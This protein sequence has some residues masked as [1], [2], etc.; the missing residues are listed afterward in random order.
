M[1]LK[2]IHS[3]FTKGSVAVVNF[4]IL[5][6]SSRYLGVSTRGE[7]SLIIL[8]L[9]VIQLI[10]EVYTGYSLV[11]YISK[12]NIHKIYANGVIFTL[13]TTLATNAVFYLIGEQIE[14]YQLLFL[15]L[16]VMVILN[17]FNCVLILAREFYKMYN[18]LSIIQPALLL[19]GIFIY[20]FI[21]KDFTLGAFLWPLLISFGISLSVSTIFVI[22][23]VLINNTSQDFELKPILINGLYCQLAAL[24]YVLSSRLSYYLLETKPDVGLSS[25]SSSLLGSGL[26]VTNSVT[27][28]LLSKVAITGNNLKSVQLTQ[29]LAKTCMLFSIL[30]IAVVYLIPDSLFILLLGNTFSGSKEIMMLLSPGIIFLSFSGIISHYYSGIGKLKTVSFYNFFGFAASIVLAPW[31]IKDHGI[32]GAALTTNVAYFI[33]FCA[34]LIVFSKDN[35]LSIRSLTE[36]KNDFRELKHLFTSGT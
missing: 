19:A 13:F 9:S 34:A 26:I 27:P 6:I 3:L 20:T 31:L 5:I 17:T 24:M 25:T 28:I 33:T 36:F 18:F 1:L 11:H 22:R 12:F 30:A 10:N 7:I 16:S 21:L 2:I 35:S 4:L 29:I 15:L 32:F 14:G 23:Y 8:N